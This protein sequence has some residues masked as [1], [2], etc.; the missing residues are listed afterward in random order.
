MTKVE[1]LEYL[2]RETAITAPM[3]PSDVQPC[4]CRWIGCKG[5]KLTPDWLFA[6]PSHDRADV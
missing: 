5:W 2:E 1:F 6:R 4:G 3:R